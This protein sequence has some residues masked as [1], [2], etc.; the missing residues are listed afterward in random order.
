MSLVFLNGMLW[1][2]AALIAVPL[3]LHLFARSKPPVYRFSSIEF[4]LRILR[5]TLRVKRPQDWLLLLLR[6][7][8][9]AT[10][11]LLFLRP[12]FFAR[13]ALAGPL[14]RKNVVLVVDAT[15]SMGCLEGGRTRFAAACAEASEVLSGLTAS[16]RANV[17]W[18]DAEPD[19]VFPEAGLNMGYLRAA[20]SRAEVRPEEGDLA[21]AVKLAVSM[22]ENLDGRSEIY[23]I[24]D[25]QRAVWD[26]AE[27][28][29]PDSIRLVY[30]RV[31]QGDGDN[32]ALSALAVDP[33]SPLKGEEV[34][35]HAEVV[36]YSER[37]RQ[38][39]VYFEAGESR[40]SLEVMI[41]AW[42]R[43]TV[44]FRHRFAEPG[45]HAVTASL[46]EDRF[47]AD[48]RRW[49][50]VRVSDG[51]AVAVSGTNTAEG[52]YWF[53]AL[54]ALP[55]ARIEPE[56]PGRLNGA[57]AYDAF[58]LAGWDGAGAE[59]LADKL[60]RGATLVCT[61]APD[62]PIGR[63]LSVAGIEASA[64]T[65]EAA[66][67]PLSAPQGTRIAA[68]ED[69]VFRLFAGG[70]YGDPAGG[71]FGARWRL[72]DGAAAGGE[73]LLEYDDGRPA[74]VRYRRGGTLYVWT[75]P[76]DP[77]FSDWA[78][79][80]EFVPFLGELLLSS[81]ALGEPRGLS[82]APGGQLE[83]LVDREV[84]ASDVTLQDESGAAHPLRALRESGGTR[85]LSDG[86]ARVGLFTWRHEGQ[87]QQLTAVNFPPIESDL[88][89]MSM[90]EVE[91]QGEL[92]LAAGRQARQL[93]DGLPLW[94]YLLALALG[95]A[96][97]EGA[98][99][100]WVERT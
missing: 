45:L 10:L 74:L 39:T 40:R 11:L 24:S 26:K 17:V 44:S 64:V 80:V 14:A 28:A 3:L 84:L 87:P 35:I 38:Q 78:G 75:M 1:P 99:Q 95:W 96:L 9:F 21:G 92:A 46:N 6:T 100:Y 42:D 57:A 56:D 25:F 83:W 43:T 77:G 70:E 20:L 5:T 30:L 82:A 49:A 31:A 97:L 66:W 15:A 90:N 91:Q 98:A 67:E 53:R 76:L 59:V 50:V 27:V 8:L 13:R 32:S 47:P 33:P 72:P 29:V 41:P 71:R 61:P 12:L 69:R 62:A 73:V 81:R 23:V 60:A 85:M 4:I 18:L 88:R 37:P 19:P 65:G 34:T 68:K 89:T 54:D 52:R 93:R 86:A 58:L 22:L 36:N 94:P 48:D 63:L 7:A 2:L 79:R 51:L 55:W 16:D